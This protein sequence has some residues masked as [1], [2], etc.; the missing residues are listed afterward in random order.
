[1]YI[2][3]SA[4]Y[5]PLERALIDAERNRFFIVSATGAVE[6]DERDSDF[7]LRGANNVID[8]GDMLRQFSQVLRATA[9]EN[10]AEH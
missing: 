10:T 7:W 4:V 2:V 8:F 9:V 5:A 1:M 3:I 6:L